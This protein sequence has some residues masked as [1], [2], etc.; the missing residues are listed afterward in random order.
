DIWQRQCPVIPADFTREG[1]TGEV[2]Q[3]KRRAEELVG[4]PGKNRRGD[5]VSGD[6]GSARSAARG[7]DLRAAS[8]RCIARGPIRQRE[9]ESPGR[10]GCKPGVTGS[11]RAMQYRITSCRI[12]AH[13]GLRGDRFWGRIG[14]E[15]GILM[16][17]L[18]Y[19]IGKFEWLSPEKEG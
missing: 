4:C 16:S 18:R 8:G 12:G 3:R 17:D 19:P 11:S 5:E 14:C 15:R 7:S 6:G 13:I 1:G 2:H 10:R 9:R